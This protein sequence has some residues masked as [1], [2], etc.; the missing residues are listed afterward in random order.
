MARPQVF[1]GTTE[2]VSGFITACKLY[3]R[4]K[5]R[6]EAVEKQIQQIFLYVQERSADVQKENTLENLEVGLL[7]YEM[8]GEFLAEIKKKFGEGDEEIVKVAELKRLEQ[9]EKTI[10]EFVQE[11]RRVARESR[12]KKQLLIE[13]FKRRMNGIIC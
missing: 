8:T 7:E 5:M 6:E 13:E 9:G 10:E 11:F 4:M 1:D 2:K 3:I 12:Y